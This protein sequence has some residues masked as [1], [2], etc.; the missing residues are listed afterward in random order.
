M[1]KNKLSA[2]FESEL[3]YLLSRFKGK[4]GFDKNISIP[5]LMNALKRE[6][7][8]NHNS[9]H[10]MLGILSHYLND[11]LLCLFHQINSPEKKQGDL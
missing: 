6:A 5:I 9:Y 10:D 11:N 2:E 1:E 8:F 4:E 3:H 7:C